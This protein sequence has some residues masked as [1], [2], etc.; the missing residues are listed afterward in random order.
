MYN[1]YVICRIATDIMLLTPNMHKGDLDTKHLLL[2][3]SGLDNK[4]TVYPLSLDED[5]AAK[6]KLVGTHT[7]YLSCCKF[8]NSDQQVYHIRPI[9]C[10][11]R[12]KRTLPFFSRLS[13][14][15]RANVTP[16][17]ADFAMW[18]YYKWLLS[19]AP[20]LP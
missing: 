13:D 4:C 2:R 12:I 3:C 8:T 1:I 19:P 16:I 17:S 15:R 11:C 20:T 18:M 5:P 7:S 9:K 14:N 6:K 10:T